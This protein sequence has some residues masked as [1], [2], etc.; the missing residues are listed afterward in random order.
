MRIDEFSAS[1]FGHARIIHLGSNRCDGAVN[2]ALDYHRR[3]LRR[4]S[5]VLPC[6]P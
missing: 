4:R 6:E 3:T 5:H 2:L 1:R